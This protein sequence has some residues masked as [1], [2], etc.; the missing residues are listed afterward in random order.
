MPITRIDVNEFMNLESIYSC[1]LL[2]LLW[3]DGYL[4][5]KYSLI[6][7][8]LVT[9]DFID[10]EPILNKLG[11]WYSYKK[12]HD[13]WQEVTVARFMSKKASEFLVGLDFHK[14]SETSPCKIFSAIPEENKK[15]FIR[16]WFDGD[17]CFYFYP[18]EFLRQSQIGGTYTQDWS[19]LENVLTNLDIKYT[20]KRQIHRSGSRSSAIRFGGIENIFKFGEYIYDGEQFGLSRK[21]NKYLEIVNSGSRKKVTSKITN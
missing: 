5:L 15:Y 8:G 4:Y 17:G 19:T 14:K 3:A 16:G 20:I 21:K 6:V 18:K 1:Y 10:I 13:V 9:K 2:G 11:K 12:A 7:L